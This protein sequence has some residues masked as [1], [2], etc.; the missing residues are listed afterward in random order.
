MEEKEHQRRLWIQ[1]LENSF[2]KALDKSTEEFGWQEKADFLEVLTKFV[3]TLINDP[4]QSAVFYNEKILKQYKTKLATAAKVK[5]FWY[6]DPHLFGLPNIHPEL[7]EIIP[8]EEQVLTV[9]EH[10]LFLKRRLHFLLTALENQYL[11]VKNNDTNESENSMEGIPGLKG[12]IKRSADDHL[13]K[14]NQ[15]QT[16]LLIEYLK[17][18]RIILKD[19][20]LNDKQAGLGFHIL[21]G[22]SP[23]SLRIKL[24]E[25]GISNIKTKANLK[26]LYNALINITNLI[27]NDLK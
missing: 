1:E 21:T 12:R 5:L 9:E 17:K 16:A 15:E 6:F 24:S 10:H 13:T 25:K 22:Y 7:F 4:D 20:Y 14:L 27:S 11:N 8:N 19:E 18:G 26:E 2:N 3:E 23:D